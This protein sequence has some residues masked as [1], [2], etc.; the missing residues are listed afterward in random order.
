[1]EIQKQEDY[2]ST[3]TSGMT[4]RF[5]YELLFRIATAEGRKVYGYGFEIHEIDRPVI[6]KLLA[7]AL[8]DEVVAAEEGIDFRK[9]ILLTGCVGCGK[10]ALINIVRKICPDTFKPVIKLCREISIEFGQ[11]GFDTI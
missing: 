3:R 8:H 2:T 9:G 10:T 6:R 7:Y 11:K 4:S 1:M 5:D